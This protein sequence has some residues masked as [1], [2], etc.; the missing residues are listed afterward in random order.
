VD[1]LENPVWHALTGPQATVAEGGDGARRYVPD[2][3]PFCALPD[4]P[5]PADWDALRALV[6]PGGMAVLFRAHVNL[7]D[8]WDTLARV[9]GTQMVDAGVEARP[10]D[11]AVELAASDVPEMLALVERTK[12]GPFLPRTNTLGR[13]LGYR[14]HGV[15]AAMAGE[16]RRPP[17]FVEISA[18]CTDPAYQRQGLAAAL[19]RD[20]CGRAT[21][22]GSTAML[23]VVTENTNAI[24]LY[25]A[26][27]FKE[28][29][30]FEVVVV[31]HRG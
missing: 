4:V 17:G 5:Q 30:T 11:G 29:R 26:L 2:V 31:R 24:R 16:R 8:G 27:G 13:Y 15:L 18:V 9:P 25:A 10:A 12:P 6:G 28:T 19:V 3:A 21:E 1:P 22:A 14:F 23:H 20:L 7:P